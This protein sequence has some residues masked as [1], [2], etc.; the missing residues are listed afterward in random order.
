MTNCAEIITHFNYHLY[1]DKWIKCTAKETD[2]ELNYMTSSC[3]VDQFTANNIPGNDANTKHHAFDQHANVNLPESRAELMH[4]GI[5]RCTSKIKFWHAATNLWWEETNFFKLRAHMC[6][7]CNAH[8]VYFKLISKYAF[9][10]LLKAFLSVYVLQLLFCLN[11]LF[12][13]LLND[14]KHA[15][16]KLP[17]HYGIY[18]MHSW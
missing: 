15:L 11:K 12:L 9:N 14:S 6:V 16:W 18:Q 17:V 5:N 4:F 13:C 3:I 7:G 10:N 1:G 8:I 2:D